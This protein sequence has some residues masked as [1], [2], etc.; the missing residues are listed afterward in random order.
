ME[1]QRIRQGERRYTC[2]SVGAR[3]CTYPKMPL[4]ALG[5]LGGFCVGGLDRDRPPPSFMFG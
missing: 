5:G 3:L 2:G 1:A 4:P